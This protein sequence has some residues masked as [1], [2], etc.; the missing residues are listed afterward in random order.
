M[1]VRPKPAPITSSGIVVLCFRRA[2]Q[3]PHIDVAICNVRVLGMVAFLSAGAHRSIGTINRFIIADGWVLRETMIAVPARSSQFERIFAVVGD[4]CEAKPSVAGDRG[5]V[6]ILDVQSDMIDVFQERTT[7]ARGDSR[8]Q[9]APTCIGARGDVA[10]RC[11]AIARRIDVNTC[12]TQQFAML[13]NA[14]VLAGFQHARIEP[15]AGVAGVVHRQDFGTIIR[16]ERNNLGGVDSVKAG[17]VGQRHF[18]VDTMRFDPV[19]VGKHIC[20]AAAEMGVYG[21]RQEVEQ[22]A[23]QVTHP[24][25]WFRRERVQCQYRGTSIGEDNVL[26]LTIFFER[27]PVRIWPEECI[28]VAQGIELQVCVAL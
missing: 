12:N 9:T 15:I 24:I 1:P 13:A 4:A 10:Q 8:S 27:I 14:K 28:Q 3:A 2:F 22:F 7:E 11:D 18:I 16:C 17:G 6:V 26:K 25:E 23:Q 21:A 5:G 19:V 20:K